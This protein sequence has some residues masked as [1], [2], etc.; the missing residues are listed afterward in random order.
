MKLYIRKNPRTIALVSNGLA[1]LFEKRTSNA[2]STQKGL[3]AKVIVQSMMESAFDVNGF[4]QITNAIFSG[5]FG[6]ITVKNQVFVGILTSSKKVGTPRWKVSNDDVMIPEETVYQVVNVNFYC[7]DSERYDS[8][9][10]DVTD[11]SYDRQ[12]SEHPCGHLKRLFSDGSFY[13]SR[14]FD[15]SNAMQ[16]RGIVN[17]VDYTIDRQDQRYVWNINQ[18]SEIIQ[19]RSRIAAQER[20]SLDDSAFL[21]FLI[22]GFCRTMTD[23]SFSSITLISRILTESMPNLLEFKGIDKN[24]KISNFVETEVIVQTR[25]SLISYVLTGGDIPLHWD[26]V[27]GQFLHG[28]RPKLLSDAKTVQPA[29]DLHLDEI[30]SK[31]GVIC[32]VHVSKPKNDAYQIISEALT[33]CA[34]EKEIPISLIEDSTSSLTKYPHRIIFV[35]QKQI[36]EFGSFAY[37]MERKIFVGKQTGAFRISCVNLFGKLNI[38]EKAISAEALELTLNELGDNA[39]ST[40]F[41]KAHE[42]LWSGNQFWLD[43][44]NT[45]HVKNPS[46]YRKIYRSLFDSTLIVG[47]YDP[48]HV[49]ISK[50]LKQIR[51]EYTSQA[52]ISIFAGTFN[53]NGK[54]VKDS[55]G[56]WLN[57]I[58]EQPN[59]YVIG[60][61]EIVELTPGQM[62]SVDPYVKTFWNQKIL[63]EINS[64]GDKKYTSLWNTQL[65]GIALFLYVDEENY[66]RIKHIEG[67]MKKTG[68][69]GISSNKG[70]I[71][72]QILMSSTKF[73]FVVSHLSAGLENVE[74]RHNDYKS[75]IKHIR[76]SKG[77]RIKDHD[78]IVWVGDFN[79]RILLS[80][81]EV[82]AAILS[83]QY[84]KLFEKDQLNQQMISG[85][86]FPYFNEK[87][88]EFPP[89][90]K[91]D[92]GTREYDTSEK[93]RI[94]AWTDRILSRGEILNQ[95]SYGSSEDIVFSDHRPVYG[96]FV[97]GITV[98]DEA[99][100]TALVNK[101][102]EDINTSLSDLTE[103]EKLTYLEENYVF[104][105]ED[106]VNTTTTQV[107]E[108]KKSKRLPPPSSDK[109]KW[110]IGNGKQVKV[111][112]NVDPNQYLLNLERGVNPFF[113][114]DEPIYIERE[115]HTRD[116]CLE[117]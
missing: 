55:L 36:Y 97:A 85:E 112:I 57:S 4:T 60:L 19:L 76:F 61:E 113:S 50:Y 115:S 44:L 89:T 99:K 100:K 51:N 11:T 107:A 2:S 84:K 94:P 78:G 23:D 62:L 6:L 5:L 101:I 72:V 111:S 1:L 26:V 95:I 69:G 18:I 30:M 110:W 31:Y 70:A 33:S 24:G 98:I 74:Q 114:S 41:W 39:I 25:K 14:D 67:D 92:P 105:K 87:E 15:I 9:L 117:K 54:A 46:K 8:M 22:R 102:K 17:R 21:T 13:Y 83:H 58:A 52:E 91:F 32:M 29:F 116:A 59:I 82:R 68:F 79:Y 12:F 49:Y 66:T 42:S 43:R 38:I 27:D 34:N 88:I 64:Y 56:T 20:I 106:S 35:L 73:C 10:E 63:N 103:E 109:K 93:M 90:Y 45:K 71:A 77:M 81:E 47:L 80:N 104:A 40:N 16:E 53:V 96:V 37:D 65:G 108:G 28:R 86:S 75:I 7:I 3:S 48:L